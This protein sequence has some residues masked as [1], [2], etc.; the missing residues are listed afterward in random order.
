MT[1][2]KFK[3]VLAVGAVLAVTGLAQAA[4]MKNNSSAKADKAAA[5]PEIVEIVDVENVPLIEES[6]T[7]WEQFDK[8][9]MYLSA[10]GQVR[11]M[12]HQETGNWISRNQANDLITLMS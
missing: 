5:Q 11:Y 6:I 1:T 10:P 3:T 4:P 9:S 8:P 7:F 2:N 12:V